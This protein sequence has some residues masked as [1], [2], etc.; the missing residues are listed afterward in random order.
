MENS[1]NIQST[2]YNAKNAIDFFNNLGQCPSA[3]VTST[4]PSD[5]QINVKNM[6]SF[7]D[8][9]A[10]QK[11][12]TNIPRPPNSNKRKNTNNKDNKNKNKKKI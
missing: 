2:D 9:I 5:S 3:P 10:L 11:S 4:Q 1:N 7:F 12:T 6:V 8:N